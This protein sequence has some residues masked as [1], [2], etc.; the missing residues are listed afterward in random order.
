SE[1]PLYS[2][3]EGLLLLTKPA[4]RGQLGAFDSA[5]GRKTLSADPN[6]MAD[7]CKNLR[8]YYGLDVPEGS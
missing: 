7:V 4:E 6:W 1:D 5:V 3:W 2:Q 8:S